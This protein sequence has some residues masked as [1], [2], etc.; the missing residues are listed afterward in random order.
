MGLDSGFKKADAGYGRDIA[1]FRGNESLQRYMENLAAVRGLKHTEEL[2]VSINDML[3]LQLSVLNGKVDPLEECHE[4]IML[5]VIG[6]V[7]ECLRRGESV[8]YWSWR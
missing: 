7:L 8:Y 3:E 6:Q 1:E 5:V 4:N 2:T